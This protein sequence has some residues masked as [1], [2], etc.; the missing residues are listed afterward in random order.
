MPDRWG[1]F[2]MVR[3]CGGEAVA[4]HHFGKRCR[5]GQALSC[6]PDDGG[7]LAEVLGAEDAG[8]YD[9][10]HLHVDT[11]VVIEAVDGSARDEQ[12][13]AW[14]YVG[15]CSLEVIDPA[16]DPHPPSSRGLFGLAFGPATNP[17]SDIPRLA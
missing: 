6:G 15:P 11:M 10:E 5:V 12:H 7:H 3:G 1:A 2:S 17:S 16:V 14:A 9:R 4:A 13:F 8:A